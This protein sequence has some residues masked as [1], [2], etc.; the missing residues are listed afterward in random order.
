V[1][2]C[3]FYY[4]RDSRPLAILQTERIFLPSHVIST[5]DRDASC[6]LTA[7]HSAVFLQKEIIKEEKGKKK[8]ERERKRKPGFIFVAGGR[9]SPEEWLP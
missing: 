2:P 9:P 7:H 5:A 8:R 4:L 3:L 6:N 1:Q